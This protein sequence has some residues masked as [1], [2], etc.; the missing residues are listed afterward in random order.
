MISSLMGYA[1]LFL[2]ATCI[3]FKLS[4]FLLIVLLL[5]SLI[6]FFYHN[7]EML[8]PLK[9]ALM[10]VMGMDSGITGA[11]PR[12][13][14]LNTSTEDLDQDTETYSNMDNTETYSNINTSNNPHQNTGAYSYMDEPSQTRQN[15]ETSTVYVNQDTG[16]NIR[17]GPSQTRQ[18]TAVKT[19]YVNG[20][21]NNGNN[22]DYDNDGYDDGSN[23]WGNNDNNEMYMYRTLL[24]ALRS[25]N[26][27]VQV[28]GEVPERYN[29][30]ACRTNDEYLQDDIYKFMND[31]SLNS[32]E[33]IKLK[34][35]KGQPINIKSSLSRSI[36][37]PSLNS[38][39]DYN[40]AVPIRAKLQQ[41]ETEIIF[42]NN[43]PLIS[44]GDWIKADDSYLVP[45]DQSYAAMI[46][47]LNFYSNRYDGLSH[48]D[49]FEKTANLRAIVSWKVI[50]DLY[51]MNIYQFS[52]QGE[53]INLTKW[54]Y[55]SKN[56][57]SCIIINDESLFLYFSEY[58]HYYIPRYIYYFQGY[59][60]LNLK[61]PLTYPLTYG[62][63]PV[64]LTYTI[65]KNGQFNNEFSLFLIPVRTIGNHDN[66]L[67]TGTL[68]NCEETDSN[69]SENNLPP[70]AEDP[71]NV[72][73]Y[74]ESWG[75]LLPHDEA[76]GQLGQLL[77]IGFLMQITLLSEHDIGRFNI[78]SAIILNVNPESSD[79]DNGNDVGDDRD[80]DVDDDGDNGDMGRYMGRYNDRHDDDDDD[81]D[82]RDDDDNDR[83]D[84]DDDDDGSG[85]SGSSGSSSGEE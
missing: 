15:M 26:R 39:Y 18:D 2:I 43:K 77:S 72:L 61:K 56:P 45:P 70:N 50:S 48:T 60:P 37:G 16:T 5:V 68:F 1:L 54:C 30:W 67:N 35:T 41:V 12:L 29:D 85:G 47:F 4:Y 13:T 75:T 23:N 65:P 25:G 11:P 71:I 51:D 76:E 22:G 44:D 10:S 9:D 62:N 84:D 58:I 64:K 27:V 8:A 38:I 32:S 19:L 42:G 83:R 57:V 73:Y 49:E 74:I 81:N 7:S 14:H 53:E 46:T 20:E 28:Y 59:V 33:K 63:L 82:R 78:A 40:F 69:Q 21:E 34:I 36:I 17:N 79:Y 31:N 3:I 24:T 52:E 80:G 66:Y 55:N 6:F